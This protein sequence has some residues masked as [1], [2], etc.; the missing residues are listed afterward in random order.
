MPNLTSEQST[1]SSFAAVTN[2]IRIQTTG[3]IND[4]NEE[5]DDFKIITE[6]RTVTLE[7][8]KSTKVQIT[9]QASR[10]VNTKREHKSI[11]IQMQPSLLA[12]PR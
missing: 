11:L 8:I 2:N 12:N 4:D 7:T 6:I 3:I 9:S 1:V 10:T 5:I